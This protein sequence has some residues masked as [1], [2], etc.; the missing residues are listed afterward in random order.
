MRILPKAVISG[1]IL[2]LSGFLPGAVTGRD[3]GNPPVAPQKEQPSQ[4]ICRY[5]PNPKYPAAAQKAKISATVLLE[6][7]VL[8]SGGVDVHNIRVVEEDPPGNGFADKAVTAAKDWKFEPATLKNG[9]PVKT[10][11]TIE[12]RFHAC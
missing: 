12:M 9:K 1:L 11:V 6:I 4:P 2:I 8:Q 3:A 7:T 5:C 10:K